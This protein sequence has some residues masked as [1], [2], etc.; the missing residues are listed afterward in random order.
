MFLEAKYFTDNT[1]SF[2]IKKKKKLLSELIGL[3]FFEYIIDF[4]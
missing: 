4:S 2:N 3:D 1:Y